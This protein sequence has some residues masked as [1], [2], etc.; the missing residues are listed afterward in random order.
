LKL[1][2]N[3]MVARNKVGKKLTRR[4]ERFVK[5]LV[6]NDGLVTNR[7][8]AI[9]AGYPPSSAHTRAFELMNPVRCPH[10]VAAIQTYRDELDEQYNVT[11]KR[12]IKV[13][14]DLRQASLEAGAYS[15]AVMAE[16]LRG[17]AANLY[18]NRSEV[19]HGS[20]DQM[21]REQ[22]EAELDKIRQSFDKIIDITPEV[23][24]Q[25]N[26]EAATPEG[27]GPLAITEGRAD[28]DEEANRD[29]KA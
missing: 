8:A 25:D 7:E 3:F 27:G 1:K 29:D 22:V 24:K 5:E 11:F 23:S 20:I 13:L 15:A 19:L 9:R 10:V 18:V 26:E 4:Q 28:D 12:H 6:A 14:A 17:Q 16:R 21:S 2:G